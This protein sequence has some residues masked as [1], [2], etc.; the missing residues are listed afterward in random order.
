MKNGYKRRADYGDLPRVFQMG[1]LRHELEIAETE[2]EKARAQAHIAHL[3]EVIEKI[4]VK[5]QAP[6]GG[7]LANPNHDLYQQSWRA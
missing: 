5:V 7:M 1:I 4:D 2:E 3:E 6:E